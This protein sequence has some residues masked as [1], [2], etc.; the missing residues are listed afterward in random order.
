LKTKLINN[1]E[2]IFDPVRRKYV[3]LTPEEWL[4]QQVLKHF[5]EIL[6]FPISL[7]SVEKLIKVGELRKR[8]DILVFKNDKPWLLVECKAES[9]KLDKQVL[10]Q[11]ESYVSSLQVN[12]FCLSNGHEIRCYDMLANVWKD[13][14][15]SYE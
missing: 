9:I 4:R 10:K 1:K 5:V 13:N 11:T 2:Y 15:P 12:Y 14:F 6:K 3:V 8:Y 7:I